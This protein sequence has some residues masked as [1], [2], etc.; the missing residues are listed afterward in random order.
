MK[1]F[2]KRI[3]LIPMFEEDGA[4]GGGGNEPN[5]GGEPNDEKTFTQEELNRIAAQEKRQGMAAVLKAL[6]FEKEEDAKAFVEKY[7]EEEEKNKGELEKANE[8]LE[9]EKN[10]KASAEKKAEML[11]KKLQVVAM[12]VSADKADDII[13]LASAKVTDDK[14]FETVLEDLKKTYPVL[15]GEDESTGTGGAGKPPR[16]GKNETE[17]GIGKRLAEQRKSSAQK[18]RSYFS[19]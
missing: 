10:A 7:R 9:T 15:F 1:D 19:N 4:G 16:G 17:G 6:G 11:E 18:K 3:N 13:T 2:V 14:P 5:E 12:G 8:A